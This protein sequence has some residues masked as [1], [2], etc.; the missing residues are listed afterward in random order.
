MPKSA[1]SD[2]DA[3]AANN[4]DVGGINIAEGCAMANLNNGMREMMAQIKT[5]DYQ[6]AIANDSITNAKLANVATATIKGRSTAGTGDPED[7]TATQ[8]TALLS[9]VVGDSGSGGTKGLVPAPGSGDAAAGK[10]LK[11]DGTFAVPSTGGMTLLGT[12]TTTSG[13][14]Q[15]LTDIP[16]GYKSLRLLF[17]GVSAS[18][19]FGLT[20]ALSSTNGGAYAAAVAIT[21]GTTINIARGV[22]GVVD[23]FGY[24]EAVTGKAISGAL[25]TDNAV[26]SLGTIPPGALTNTAAACNALRIGTDAGNLDAGSVEVYG[27]N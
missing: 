15:P 18:G 8:A 9:A 26:T 13:T 25:V 22:Y 16:S 6:T 21:T 20:L 2:W 19:T 27:V 23:I 10:F 24:T 14:T 7:L 11:A 12:I 4:T 1:V 5:A 17:R 3:V